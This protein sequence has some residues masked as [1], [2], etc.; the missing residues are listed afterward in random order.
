MT[1]IQQCQSKSPKTLYKKKQK[2]PE[3]EKKNRELNPTAELFVYVGLT[4]MYHS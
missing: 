2:G 4:G 3:T 1:N